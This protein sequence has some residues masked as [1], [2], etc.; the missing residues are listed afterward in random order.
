MKRNRTELRYTS[1]LFTLQRLISV[2]RVCVCVYG[3][4]LNLKE[5]DTDQ[6]LKQKTGNTD[7]DN[8]TIRAYL[9]VSKILVYVVSF[10][11]FICRC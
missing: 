2:F 3:S 4:G 5:N 10:Y 1:E 9:P 6:R 7:R 11:R 8:N